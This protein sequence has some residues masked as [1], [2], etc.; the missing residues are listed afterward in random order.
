MVKTLNLNA[1]MGHVLVGSMAIVFIEF[2]GL[3]ELPG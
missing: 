3:I 1:I 2:V